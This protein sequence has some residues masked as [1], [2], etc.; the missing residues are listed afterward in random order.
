[1]KEF[2]DINALAQRVNE[3]LPKG[4]LLNTQGEKFNAMVIGWGGLGTVWSRPAF[5]VYVREGRYTRGA[6]DQTGA[7]T[8]SVPLEKPDA[9]VNKVCGWQ[10][11]RDVDKAAAAG[12]HLEPAEV[13]GVPGVREYPITLECRVLYAQKQDLERIPEDIRARMY[14]QDV[15]GAYPMANRDAH[16]MYIGEIVS[17]YRI[18]QE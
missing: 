8:I 16:V 18:R 6:L 13:N 4:I 12:L 2:M 17:A 7:F 9:A 1:M 5:T 3:A 15:D 14:P 11:G 10:S